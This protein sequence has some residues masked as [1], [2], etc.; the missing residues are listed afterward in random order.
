[1]D[2]L[3]DITSLKE[4]E[5]YLKKVDPVLM[6]KHLIEKDFCIMENFI[7]Q[8]L[9]ES[10]KSEVYPKEFEP[11][12]IYVGLDQ[13]GIGVF[14]TMPDIRSDDNLWICGRH[15]TK[16]EDRWFDPAGTQP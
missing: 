16:V 8:E 6:R 5:G 1:M 13:G 2:N 11:S 14:K 4:E 15:R 3:I 9:A 12:E 7:T 10:V